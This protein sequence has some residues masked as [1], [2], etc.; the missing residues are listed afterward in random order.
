MDKLG[1]GAQGR[2]DKMV[3]KPTKKIVALKVMAMQTDQK[4]K[5]QILLELQTLHNCDCDYIV[6]SY[7]AFINNGEVNIALEFMDHGTL[8]HIL[9][10]EKKIP[11]HILGMITYQILQGIQ[12]L[13]KSMKV[14]HRDLKPSN[15]LLNSKGQ[16]KIADFGVSG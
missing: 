10:R 11:E 1:E 12:Y 6:R 5:K 3:H 8:T 13:H 7:G 4:I 14:I 15:I 2:V 9:K 16:V